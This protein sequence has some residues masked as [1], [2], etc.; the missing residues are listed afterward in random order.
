MF[1]DIFAAHPLLVYLAVP[2]ALVVVY[3]LGSLRYIPNNRVGIVEKR[4][5]AARARSS[6]GFIALARRGRL[7]AR[8]AARRLALP[9]ARSSTA[10]TRMPLVTIPQGKIGYVFARDGQPLPPTQTLASQRRRATTS[11]TS[12]A[13]LAQRRP[14]RPAAQD[15]ARGHLRHQ[16]RAVRRHHRGAAS[17]T[18]RSS[19]DEDAGVPARW[20]SCIAERGGF[21]PVV[22]KGADDVIGIVTVHDGPSLPAGRDHRAD[23]RRRPGRR[24]DLPQQLPGPGEVPRAPAA[25][26]AASSRCWSRARTT[27]T[28]CSRPSRLIPK[29]IVEVGNVG[30]VV[31]YT[32]ETGTDLSG[33]ELQARR[34]GARRARAACGAS[35]CCPASTRS[36]P[37]PARSS[38]CRPPT[39][40]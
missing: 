11:R 15:P 28:G 39:S 5:R 26:A 12:R 19:K 38:W 17:T 3:V 27:S 13:F 14:A 33:D 31:S 22:I 4:C 16:P 29:T 37:T 34:A 20:R 18:C 36:T 1:A 10:C 32:G 40:S 24:R 8:R 23:R 35:R 30:V 21:A 2:V 6:S 7:P 25:S 9:A